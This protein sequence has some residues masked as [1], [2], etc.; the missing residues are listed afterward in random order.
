MTLDPNILK[1]AESWLREPIDGKAQAE[2]R[3]MIDTD[4]DAL[5][6]CFYKDLDFGTG[7]MRGIMGV[8]SNR[9]NRYTLGQATQG[10]SNYLRKQFPNETISVAIAFD[11]RNNSDT[12]ALDVAKVFAA[13]GISVRLF[14]SL[15]PTPELS[16]TIRHLNCHAGIVLTASHNPKEYNGYKV[17]WNDGGQLVPPHDKAIIEEVRN[18]ELSQVQFSNDDAMIK[19]IGESVDRA[20]LEQVQQLSIG[21]AGKD[22]LKIVFTPLHGTSVV[23][24]EQALKLTGFKNVSL[25][26]DQSEPDGNFPTVDSPN[27]EEAAALDMAVKQADR[28]G[29]DLVIGCD[30]DTDR[31]GIAVR[32]H[33][34]NMKL[35]NGN[36]TGAVLMDYILGQLHAKGKLPSN[37]FSATTIV[38]SNLMEDIAL[39]YGVESMRCLTGFKWIADLIRENEGAKKFIVG[40]EESY[41]Y[42]VGDFVRDKDAI[43][44]AVMIAEAAAYA[45]S[46]GSSYLGLLDEIHKKH[47]F[48][49]ERLI[50]IKK[51]GKAGAEAIAKMMEDL[52]ANPP[53]ELAERKVVELKDYQQGIIRNL[54]DGTEKPTGLPKSNVIQ[55]VN[56]NGDIATARPSG[57]EPKIK[58]YFSVKRDWTGGSSTEMETKLNGIIDRMLKDL[59]I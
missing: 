12:L 30:P 21:N 31:V 27:P 51:E 43:S 9:I 8:G 54:V 35:L 38:T 44:A 19:R 59:S 39:G 7:G 25:V 55:V 47:G 32:D 56:E 42:M 50:S 17:Y 53:K 4:H 48:Y 40:G 37:A 52:R 11:S 49:L 15:R 3:R 6:E 33:A 16:F 41:G 22:E 57:T 14:E 34:G 18:V 20:Y 13:N 1:K 23:L 24:M 46:I 26:V 10:L 45:K 36:Q 58:F 2:V 28:E 29:A 5:V